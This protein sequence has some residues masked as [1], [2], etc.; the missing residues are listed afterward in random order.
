[1]AKSIPAMYTGHCK[2]CRTSYGVGT[3]ITR[4]GKSWVHL[5]C[6]GTTLPEGLRP[7]NVPKPAPEPEARPEIPTPDTPCYVCHRTVAGTSAM[8]APRGWVH[9]G[10]LASSPAPGA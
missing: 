3:Q 7:F 5:S 10:C 6:V 2:V 9:R 1:M 8:V 4:Y